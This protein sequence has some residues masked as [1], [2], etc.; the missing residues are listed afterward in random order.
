LAAKN[1]IN[2]E[3]MKNNSKLTTIILEIKI[4]KKNR[5]SLNFDHVNNKY[6]EKHG[7]FIE[8]ILKVHN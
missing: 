3:Y 7:L 1:S 5:K 4:L 8:Y 6:P 2:E